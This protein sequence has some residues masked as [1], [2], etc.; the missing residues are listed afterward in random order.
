VKWGDGGRDD[1]GGNGAYTHMTLLSRTTEGMHNLFRMS[2]LAS[3]EG[4]Y[5][6]PRM[7]RDLLSR[8]AGGLIGTTGCVGGEIQTRL[9]FGQYAEAARRRANCRTSSARSTSTPR[10]WTTA[11]HRAPDPA[12]LLR[13]A[14][15]LQLPLLATNDLHYTNA[16][17]AKAHAAL[18]CVQSA[19]TLMDPGRFKFDADSFYLRSAAEMRRSSASCPQACDNTLRIAEHVRGLLRGE[20]GAVHAPLPLPAGGGRDVLVHQGGRDRAAGALPRRGAG[21]SASRRHTRST[22]SSARAMPAT[23]SSSPTSSTGPRTMAS[24]SARGA[25][26]VPA[27]CAPM[28]CGSPISTRCGT[29]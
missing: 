8:Y 10:S 2:S 25:A 6:K 28:P 23:S 18:L 7:D 11:R 21:E 20:G 24:G 17:D 3:L 1:I 29:A 27:R 4:H 22:S 15:E 12:E 14:K 26:R 19:S 13:L 5:Y 9:R 16:E